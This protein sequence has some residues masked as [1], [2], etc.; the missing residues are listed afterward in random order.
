MTDRLANCLEYHR[1][2]YAAFI[3]K[4]FKHFYC[5]ILQVDEDVP[6]QR[7]HVINEAFKGSPKKWVVQRRDVDSFYG[8]AFEADFTV[9]QYFASMTMYESF[10]NKLLYSHFSP[11]LYFKDEEIKCYP[12]RYQRLPKGHHTLEIPNDDPAGEP[13]R[14]AFRHDNPEEIVASKK[15]WSYRSGKDIRLAAHVSILKAAYLSLFAILGYRYACSSAGIFMG[16]DIL[17]KFF[18]AN[19]ELEKYQVLSNATLFFHE[20]R[21]MVRPLIPIPPE[22]VGTLLNGQIKLCADATGFPSGMIV[23]VKTAN[24]AHA[25]LTPWFSTD[26]QIG[27]FL[28]FIKSDQTSVFLLDGFFDK[29][30]M[31]WKIN[32][33]RHPAIWPKREDDYPSLAGPQEGHS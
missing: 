2:E 7:G 8:R 14:L 30:A 4:P 24:S 25:V 12:Y 5:P 1:S 16:Y 21:H 3:G 10:E 31:A 15:A 23:F 28:K 32:P 20:F 33:D 18:K 19:R 9:S 6:L 27:T 11:K 13:Y 17:G 22:L 29:E 26:V